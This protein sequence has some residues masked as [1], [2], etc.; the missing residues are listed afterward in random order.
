M[1]NNLQNKVN[2]VF[3]DTFGRT[4]LKQRIDDIFSE[5]IEISRYTDDKNLDEE[6]GDCLASLIAL[7]AERG[8]NYEVLVNN[9]LK[10]IT[11]RKA[12]YKS[13]GRKIKVAILGGAFNP[14]TNGHIATAQFVLNTSKTFDEVWLM[15]CYGHMYGKKMVSAK[16]RL[17]MC[18]LAASVD[19]RI[20]VFDYEIK[21]K[22]SGETYQTVKLLLEEKFAK[23][24]Y[25]F[26]WVIGQDNANTFDKWVNYELLERMI[27][28]VVVPRDGI[29]PTKKASWYLKE[30][31]I[32]ITDEH[33]I[34]DIS[35]TQVRNLLKSFY[36]A[37]GNN[38]V[39]FLDK[40]REKV[41]KDVLEYIERNELYKEC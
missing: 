1:K 36:K 18:R 6:V 8:K 24:Q 15:P 30:P 39:F 37:S 4:P 2:K 7:C 29:P 33:N 3:T 21:N 23:E 14:I 41:H 25:D 34:G 22:L 13:L 12:Q 35:S 9:T 11:N 19:G 5:A 26:S 38:D 31:H 28:F 32:H 27:R 40:A 10:K 17:E 20:K 16:R